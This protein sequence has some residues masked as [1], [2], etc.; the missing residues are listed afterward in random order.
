MMS[1][2]VQ[3]K[4]AKN[5]KLDD[6]DVEYARQR[7]IA[8]PDEYGEA[9][10]TVSQLEPGTTPVPVAQTGPAYPMPGRDQQGPGVFLT[11]DEL[12]SL[13]AAEIESVAEAK[14]VEIS[15]R[16]KA[17]KVASLVGGGA[18]AEEAEAEAESDEEE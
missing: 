7:G 11:A 6:D 17:A 5:Q 3:E 15:G 10:G 2:N 9:S 14:G 13:T 8:L 18:P 4:L 12:E 1:R 16:S